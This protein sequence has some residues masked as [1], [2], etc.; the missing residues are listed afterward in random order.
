MPLPPEVSRVGHRLAARTG[1]DP[2]DGE[3]IAGEVWSQHPD[4]PG[5]WRCIAERRCIDEARHRH[6]SVRVGS[7]DDELIDRGADEPG[8]DAAESRCD[9]A[10][11]VA[12]LSDRDL[13]ALARHYWLGLPFH[14]VDTQRALRRARRGHVDTPTLTPRQREV[15]QLLAAG[16]SYEAVGRE[17]GITKNTVHST[18]CNL[19]KALGALNAPHAVAIA[20]RAGLID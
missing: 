8:F 2:A 19:H 18:V 16:R 6:A 14:P 12:G 7:L 10:A 11:M 3:S 13:A 15:L 20:L 1:L 17:L 5:L 4:E 9:V